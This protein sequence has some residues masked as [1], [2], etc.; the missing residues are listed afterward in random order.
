MGGGAKLENI[1]QAIR[2]RNLERVH[3]TG[4]IPAEEQNAMLNACNVAVISLAKGMY[5]LSVPSKSY[6]NMAAGKPLLLIADP[7]SEIER[8]IEERKIGWHVPPE[9]PDA[10]ADIMRK[11]QTLSSEELFSCGDRARQTAAECFSEE[12]ILN[13]YKQVIVDPIEKRR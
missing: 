1:R 6:F 5:G 4:W 13:H 10:L 3:A 8:I 9:D 2:E 7:G 11:I 12:L